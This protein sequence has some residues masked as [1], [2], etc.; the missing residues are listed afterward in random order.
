MPKIPRISGHEAIRAF[1]RVGYHIMRQKGSHIRLKNLQDPTRL[2][3]SVPDHQ[4]LGIGLLRKL[5]RDSRVS[6]D[7]FVKLLKK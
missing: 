5:L 4:E 7:E 6:V 3:L 2:P 1:E